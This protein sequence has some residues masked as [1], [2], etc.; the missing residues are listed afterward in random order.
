MTAPTAAPLKKGEEKRHLLSGQEDLCLSLAV[1]PY[2][3]EGRARV[4][5]VVVVFCQYLYQIDIIATIEQRL[6]QFQW[7]ITLQPA[8]RPHSGHG[9]GKYYRRGAGRLSP[10]SSIAHQ[11]KR[12]EPSDQH[13]ILIITKN[14]PIG[15]LIAPRY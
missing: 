12:L 13:P 8:A 7:V 11:F 2:E 14:T 4:G 3:G 15:S 5:L 1:P 6:I 9:R 10:A